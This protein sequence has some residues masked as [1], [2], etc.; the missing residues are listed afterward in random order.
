ML[1]TPTAVPV[2]PGLQVTTM[3]L[4]VRVDEQL[5]TV[6]L[7]LTLCL[8]RYDDQY[9]GHLEY[10][11][12]LFHPGTVARMLQS[13]TS[14][15][16]RVVT[17]PELRLADLLPVTPETARPPAVASGLPGPEAIDL[18]LQAL[19]ARRAGPARA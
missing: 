15:L 7:D 12:A 17:E 16:E 3:T 2:L 8:T 13:Y 19:A 14:M 1:E 18:A 5:C 11:A 10:N 4:P 9:A 6:L